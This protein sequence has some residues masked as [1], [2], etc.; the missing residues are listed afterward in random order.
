MNATIV[1]GSHA[2]TSPMITRSQTMSPP[3]LR[4]AGAWERGGGPQQI[5]METVFAWMQAG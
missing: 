1:T 3:S 4:A 2:I 5:A